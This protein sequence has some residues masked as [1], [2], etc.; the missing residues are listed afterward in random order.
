MDVITAHQH[1]FENV[2]AASGTG[3]SRKQVRSIFRFDNEIALAF[4]SDKA[5]QEATDRAAKI[6]MDWDE[7]FRAMQHSKNKDTR[8]Y[9]YA[10]LAHRDGHK[11]GIP[12]DNL[13]AILD[14]YEM[15]DDFLRDHEIVW[16]QN[17]DK[18]LRNLATA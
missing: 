5:G 2:V 14:N 17:L 11:L 12:V 9:F 4:D 7:E 8:Q 16:R 15:W 1:G 6:I 10:M 3:L 13:A 18:Y